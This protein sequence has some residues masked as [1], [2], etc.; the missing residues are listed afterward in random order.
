VRRLTVAFIGIVMFAP[1]AAVQAADLP[2][3]VGPGPAVYAPPTAFRAVTDWSGFYIGGNIGPT[4]AR[5]HSDFSAGG[6]PFAT[7]ER[8]YGALLVAGRP[9][10]IGNPA[11]WSWARRA[12][13]S[14]A[15]SRAA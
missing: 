11:P 9:A 4:M 14:G 15:I 7:T 8:R 1:V 3:P 6:V 5:A 12:I 2:P 10:L 13:F